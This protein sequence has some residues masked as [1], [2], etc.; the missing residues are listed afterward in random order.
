MTREEAIAILQEEIDGN[1]ELTFSEW[2]ERDEQKLFPAIRMA[3]K[4]L[5]ADAVS[6]EVYDKRTQADEEIID[7]YRQEFQK[8]LSADA[9][10]DAYKRGFDDCKRAYEIEL[11]RSA[12]D[13]QGEW[14]PC[15]EK[16]PKELER[17]NITWLNHNPPF[18]YQH[19]KDIPQT[20][21]AVYYRGKWYWWD[22]AVIDILAEYGED[23]NAEQIDKDIE[24]VA[25]M[26]L[27]K[28]YKG[29]DTE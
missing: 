24:V 23:R 16:M 11:A 3:I 10:S 29:G 17:V 19:I 7:S 22:V 13:A 25:W 5:Q 21:T 1:L 14:I 28:P 20:D 15:R 26:P 2:R 18:Y 4:A 8:A 27:P 9:G 12:Y 6:R